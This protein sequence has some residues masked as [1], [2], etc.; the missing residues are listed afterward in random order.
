MRGYYGSNGDRGTGRYVGTLPPVSA[1]MVPG[2][3]DVEHDPGG[4]G[5][6]VPDGIHSGERLPSLWKC[7]RRGTQAQLRPLHGSGLPTYPPP[8]VAH[9]VP[10]GVQAPPSLP[11]NRPNEGGQNLRG[12]T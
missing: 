9:Q 2:W 11:T 10:W 7:L 1:L 6:A 3:E 5:G 4:E 12:P 8:E